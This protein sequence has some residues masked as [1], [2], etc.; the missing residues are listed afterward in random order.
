MPGAAER[1]VTVHG[2]GRSHQSDCRSQQFVVTHYWSLK[3]SFPFAISL[4]F[5]LHQHGAALDASCGTANS[6]IGARRA[7]NAAA[8]RCA[9]TFVELQVLGLR[10]E[11]GSACSA[12]VLCRRRTASAGRS[13]KKPSLPCMKVGASSAQCAAA[14]IAR[15]GIVPGES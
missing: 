3:I 14:V 12:K 13:R 5:R 15:W 7:V 9:L 1:C 11:D 4:R 10:R 6:N 2:S 8:G